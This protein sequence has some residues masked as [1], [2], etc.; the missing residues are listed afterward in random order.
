MLDVASHIPKVEIVKV[1]PRVIGEDTIETNAFITVFVKVKVTMPADKKNEKEKEGEKKEEKKEEEF[2]EEEEEEKEWWEKKEQGGE[3]AHAPYW[4]SVGC[5]LSLDYRRERL[6]NAV[7]PTG[8]TPRLVGHPRHPSHGLRRL[9]AH[10]NHGSGRGRGK[11][12]AVAVFRTERNGD[13]G[14]D[15]C[16][17]ER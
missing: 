5:L 14:D 12:G 9:P 4:P 8:E 6:T 3:L 13:D 10:Q 1:E 7:K 17:A 11:N 16:G 2:T 15:G